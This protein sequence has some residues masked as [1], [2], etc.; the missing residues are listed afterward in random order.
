MAG[1]K[2]SCP[3]TQSNEPTGTQARRAAPKTVWDILM[4][5]SFCQYQCISALV[6]SRMSHTESLF[7][8][9]LISIISFLLLLSGIT[10]LLDVGVLYASFCTYF[11]PW[12]FGK[13]QVCL[14]LER[15]CCIYFAEVR[16]K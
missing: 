3:V 5:L 6:S 11:T 14:V 10:L 13:L 9:S 12:V 7:P 15:K 4:G 2:I 16:S 8:L 1:S